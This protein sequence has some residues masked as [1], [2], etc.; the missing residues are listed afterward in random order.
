MEEFARFPSSA[1]EKHDLHTS[2]LEPSLRGA[3]IRSIADE[4]SALALGEG[5]TSFEVPIGAPPA[6]VT[7]SGCVAASKLSPRAAENKRDLP[8]DFTPPLLL[9][10][11]VSPLLG[12]STLLLP[13]LLLLFAG[14]LPPFS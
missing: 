11:L 6:D 7:A 10:A 8:V 14:S 13:L 1:N 5:V 2:I 9:F 12:L 4:S 3:T